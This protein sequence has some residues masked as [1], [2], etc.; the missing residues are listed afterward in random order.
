MAMGVMDSDSG[1]QDNVSSL[2]DAVQ[3][4]TGR[5]PGSR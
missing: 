5:R 3:L 1:E 4:I 2:F